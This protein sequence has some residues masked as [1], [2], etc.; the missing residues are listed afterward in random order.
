M[1]AKDTYHDAVKTALTKDGWTITDDPLYLKCGYKDLFIDLGAE[2]LLAAE[3]G[4][5]KIA[6]EVKSFVAIRRWMIWK[7]RWANSSFITTFSRAPNRT[8]SCSWR[9]IRKSSLN[10]LKNRSGKSSWKTGDCG[11]LCSIP[12]RR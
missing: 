2:Q 4:K 11:Y 10:S 6:V 12:K 8:E 1:P 5:R 7:R 9:S 3:K